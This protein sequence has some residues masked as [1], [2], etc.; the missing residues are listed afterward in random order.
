MILIWE[1]EE[2]KKIEDAADK[3]LFDARED[4]EKAHAAD[5]RVQEA[6]EG[7]IASPSAMSADTNGEV[8]QHQI[9]M[10]KKKAE[11]EKAAE[12]QPYYTREKRAGRPGWR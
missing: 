12:K 4:V 3:R 6:V 5:L 1:V 9:E 2:K 8:S 10:L 7:P 11:A